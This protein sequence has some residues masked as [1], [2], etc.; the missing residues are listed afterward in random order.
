MEDDNLNAFLK[1]SKN[2][3]QDYEPSGLSSGEKVAFALALWQWGADVNKKSEVLLID[4]FDAHL[5]PSLMQKYID[6]IKKSFV[7][8]GVQ[9]I[10]TTHDPLIASMVEE[11]DVWWMENDRI[12]DDSNKD[13]SRKSKAKIVS[14]LSNGLMTIKDESLEDGIKS[15]FASKSTKSNILFVEAKW[16]KLHLE[17]A[18]LHLGLNNHISFDILALGGTLVTPFISFAFHQDSIIYNVLKDKN[19]YF[20]FDDDVADRGYQKICNKHNYLQDKSFLFASNC[21]NP[22][23]SFSIENLYDTQHYHQNDF[24]ELQC[25]CNSSDNRCSYLIKKD[26]KKSFYDR[27]KRLTCNQDA[28]ANKKLFKHFSKLLKK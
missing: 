5:N 20:L 2:G 27:I 12:F 8:K 1:F 10:I 19:I 17:M 26:N 16:D 15:L 9:V 25:Q 7:E 24:D 21:N 28:N 4:E 3:G 14:K 23:K 13:L 22:Q 11:K 18:I 6:V